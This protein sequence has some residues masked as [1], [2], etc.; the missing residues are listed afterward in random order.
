[1]A[2]ANI[3]VSLVPLL[4][5]LYVYYHTRAVKTDDSG[6]PPKCNRGFRGRRPVG[7]PRGRWE[8]AAWRDDVYL[9]HRQTGKEAARN[10]EGM[11]KE[12]GE[13]MTRKQAEAP[14]KNKLARM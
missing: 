14:N 7:E 8:D 3:R 4:S 1:M 10:R 5:G 6:H 13:A 11:R 9:L 2:D 12:I